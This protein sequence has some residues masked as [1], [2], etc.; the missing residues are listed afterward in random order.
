[1]FPKP[2]KKEDVLCLVQFPL[3]PPHPATAC[4]HAH[5][6][7]YTHTHTHP[8]WFFVPLNATPTLLLWKQIYLVKGNDT[9]H[10]KLVYCIFLKMHHLQNLRV[11]GFK[12]KLHYCSKNPIW[13]GLLYTDDCG[14][15]LYI[16]TG[17]YTLGQYPQF[18][19]HAL[20]F[21]SSLTHRTA[22]AQGINKSS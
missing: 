2:S 1:M 5:V 16:G 15:A 18:S 11:T 21:P 12:I 10:N 4:V 20:F 17:V 3:S 19:T 8:F 14:C 13:S 22:I 9:F 7:T 6:H